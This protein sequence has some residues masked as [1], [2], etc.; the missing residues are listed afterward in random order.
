MATPFPSILPIEDDILELI[1][2]II[3]SYRTIQI[4]SLICYSITFILGV[5]G[6]G[7][8]IWIAGFKMKTVSAV[9]F[10]NLAIADIICN[11]SLP[12]RI[13]QWI[14]ALDS[15]HDKELCK[16]AITVMFINMFASVYFLTVISLDRCVSV[17][18]PI[19]SK[20]HRTHRRASIVASCT[21]L[22]CLIS[23]VPHV[24]SNFAY[25]DTS[26]CFPKYE[27]WAEEDDFFQKI[28]VMFYIR[29][30][31]M[32]SL[33]FIVIVISYIL[34]AYKVKTTRRSKSFQR[35]LRIIIT[36]VVCFFICWFP[37]NTWPFVSF[38][39]EYFRSYMIISE[40]CVCLAYFN[41]CINPVIYVFF[42]RD[43]KQGFMRSMPARLESIFSEHPE[44]S[45][46]S[47]ERQTCV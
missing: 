46:M 27:E 19:W 40:I 42:S 44:T 26:E 3:R 11:L 8:V 2:Y 34:I 4:L 43:F 16:V 32:F 12:F 7:L 38:N 31:F 39:P 18:W 17:M 30:I 23:S 20:I 14:I 41:S 9:W 24:I 28:N 22:L 35:P 15:D 45:E 10:L 6:N 21:W 1:N 5:L 13:A 25:K 47:N 37:Y 36:V 29:N 33:P